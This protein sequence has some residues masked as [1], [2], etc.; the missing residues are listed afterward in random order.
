MAVAGEA[1]DSVCDRNA[2]VQATSSTTSPL[3][4]SVEARPLAIVARSSS[5]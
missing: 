4:A 1:F 5:S 2:S 3:K